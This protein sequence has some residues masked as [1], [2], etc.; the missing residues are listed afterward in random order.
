MTRATGAAWE[1]TLWR[2]TRRA[3]WAALVKVEE[4]RP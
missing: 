4:N 2:A 1:L 3:A